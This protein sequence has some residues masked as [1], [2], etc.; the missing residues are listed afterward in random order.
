MW[1]AGET[2]PWLL[3][4]RVAKPDVR[5]VRAG[6]WNL[7]MVPAIACL[8]FTKDTVGSLKCTDEC[9]QMGIPFNV[10]L[11]DGAHPVRETS[12]GRHKSP[13]SWNTGL[14]VYGLVGNQNEARQL[15]GEHVY[16]VEAIFVTGKYNSNTSCLMNKIQ[17]NFVHRRKTSASYI[18]ASWRLK[19]A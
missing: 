17:D 7:A 1:S 11:R 13:C 18:V 19:T 15:R 6:I 16:L 9:W 2:L 4:N 3:T 5:L 8:F 10:H 12:D 14:T